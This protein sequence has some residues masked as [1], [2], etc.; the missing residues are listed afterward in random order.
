M[1]TINNRREGGSPSDIFATL[2]GC[3]AMSASSYAS[4]YFRPNGSQ[5]NPATGRFRASYRS[6]SLTFIFFL[7]PNSPR[8]AA[9]GAFARPC[10][11]SSSGLTSSLW[12]A[13]QLCYISWQDSDRIPHCAPDVCD[14]CYCYWLSLRGAGQP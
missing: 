2:K 4:D 14:R 3:F 7:L 1:L 9:I 11:Q 13:L 10:T 5:G 6:V 12:W 8:T